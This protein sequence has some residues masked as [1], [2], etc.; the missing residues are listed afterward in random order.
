[1]N[2]TRLFGVTWIMF[3]EFP[4]I[5]IRVQEF[6]CHMHV[7]TI[8]MICLV[9]MFVHSLKVLHQFAKKQSQDGSMKDDNNIFL[10]KLLFLSKKISNMCRNAWSMIT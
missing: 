4:H 10:K 6:A 1:M 2:H 7:A 8:D 5:M 9:K 3:F